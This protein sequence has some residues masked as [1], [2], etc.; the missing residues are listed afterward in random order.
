METLVLVGAGAS[1]GSY[2][3]PSEVP[4]LGNGF[5]GLFA[6]LVT[7]SREAALLPD[8]LKQTFVRNFEEGMSEY[9]WARQGNVAR[10]QLD[11]GAYLASFRPSPGNA[12]FELLA[13]TDPSRTIY[14]SLNYDTL[15]EEVALLSG[16]NIAYSPFAP[17]H[18]VRLIKP[19]GSS[20]FWP[21]IAPGSI[22]GCTFVNCGTDVEAPV[23]CL[24]PE[25][26]RA[27]YPQEDSFSPCMSLYA[28]D[29]PVRTSPEFVK[30]QQRFFADS[31][32]HVSRIIITGVRAYPSDI[33]IWVPLFESAAELHYFGLEWDRDEFEKWAAGRSAPVR[34]HQH[35][36]RE[37]VGAIPSL[38]T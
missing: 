5:D 10:L 35:G 38:R 34:F 19:H 2:V 29:K 14:A 28:P 23:V 21:N 27:R 7:R 8:E 33:H 16:W 26:S 32:S 22:Q 3:T 20:N 15:L 36:F 4:P 11:I 37:A 24:H 30:E 25:A 17:G 18:V 12:Y 31:V 1:Y 9:F 13:A 6:R